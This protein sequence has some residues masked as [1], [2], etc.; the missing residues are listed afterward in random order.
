MNILKLKELSSVFGVAMLL[1][2]AILMFMSMIATV[3]ATIVSDVK[4]TENGDYK[5]GVQKTTVTDTE[6]VTEKKYKK[7]KTYT[8]TFNANGGKVTTKTKKLAYKKSLGTLPKPT[9]SGYEFQGW[10]TSKS[11]GKKVSANTKMPAKNTVL[12]AHWKK[13]T[14]TDAK[15]KLV[16]C[17]GYNM[18]FISG[19]L[20]HYSFYKDGTFKY[21]DNYL[22]N[23]LY[24]GKYSVSGGK[25]YFTD[26]SK[27]TAKQMGPVLTDYQK[28]PDLVMPYELGKDK[29]GEYLRISYMSSHDGEKIVTNN[30]DFFRKKDTDYIAYSNY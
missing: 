18:L 6:G 23:W 7:A 19:R 17:W 30:G 15:S 4:I 9:R 21:Y 2:V 16:G 14:N 28:M 13:N 10:Y 20:T 26:R 5:V 29:E 1:I 25:I 11:G 22:N 27:Y 8:L 12:Y 3:D 24:K